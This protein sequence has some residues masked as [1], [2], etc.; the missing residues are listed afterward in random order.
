V[1]DAVLREELYNRI[2]ELFL[3]RIERS[4]SGLVAS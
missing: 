2:M 4:K 1:E 3:D